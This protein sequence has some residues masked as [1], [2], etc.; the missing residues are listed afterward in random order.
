MH[1]EPWGHQKRFKKVSAVFS[2]G[3]AAWSP[4]RAWHQ[5]DFSLS[6]GLFNDSVYGMIS[7]NLF[8]Y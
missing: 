6:Q 4:I 1:C 3:R 2:Q 5:T 7:N 8:I